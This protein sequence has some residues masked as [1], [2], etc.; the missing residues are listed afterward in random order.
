MGL[1][2]QAVA[3]RP[4]QVPSSDRRRTLETYIGPNPQPTVAKRYPRLAIMA[5]VLPRTVVKRHQGIPGS[6]GTPTGSR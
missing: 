6:S 5:A 3:Y 1:T 2:N 4:P